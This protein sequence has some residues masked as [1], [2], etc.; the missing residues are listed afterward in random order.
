MTAD[1]CMDVGTEARRVALLF[2]VN[3]DA[4]EIAGWLHDI[5]AVFPS[6]ERIAVSRDLQIEILPEEEVFPMI[7]HQKI[8]KV[9]ARDI[10]KIT[11]VEILD[12]VGCHTTLR[13]HS[14][15]LDRVLFVAD[16]ISWD[17]LGEPPY[18]QE[19]N[20][21]LKLSLTHGAFSYINY[22]WERKD[23]LKVVHP[24]LKEAYEEMKQ[25]KSINGKHAHCAGS[26][27]SLG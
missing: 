23:T 24:W 20:R 1:H 21:S 8:S 11:N 22:L 12:A 14:T 9:M 18:I 26:D 3:P 17:Q 25:K 4:A 2:E 6:N 10:F 19:L 15:L 5:S 27:D 13:A 16:K 7:I